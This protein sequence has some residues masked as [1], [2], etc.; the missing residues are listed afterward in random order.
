MA[1]SM[2]FLVFREP[3]PSW[4]PV[5]VTRQQPP[6][7]EHDAF[8]DRLFAAGRIVLAG[9]YA[10]LRVCPESYVYGSVGQALA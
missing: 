4:V 1:M 3:G 7:D 10:H 5:V 6:W 8:M 9:P 2:L